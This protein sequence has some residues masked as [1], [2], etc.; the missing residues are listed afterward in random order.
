[1]AAGRTDAAMT[2]GALARRAGVNVQTVRYYERRGLLPDPERRA[3]GRPRPGGGCPLLD[4][5]GPLGEAAAGVTPRRSP[6]AAPA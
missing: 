3:Q 5:L 2:I 6:R 4:A 1:M